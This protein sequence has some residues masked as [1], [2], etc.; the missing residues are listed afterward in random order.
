[1]PAAIK[2]LELIR[3]L[4]GFD[5]TSRE[6]N[7]ALIEFVR[8]YLRQFG[9]AS[10]L[11]WNA[12]GSKANL[13][14]TIGPA[15]RPGVILSG[16][17]DVVPV[18]GQEWSSD[19]FT[20]READGRLYGRGTADMKGFIAIALALVPEMA[21]KHLAHPIHLAFSYDEE[22][23]CSGVQSLIGWLDRQQVK[24]QLCLV[25][26]PTDLRPTI[27]HKGGRAYKVHVHGS[28]AHSSLAPLAV[29]AVEYAA[30]L[31]V[32]LKGV[33]NEMAST[34]PREEGYDIVHSTLQTG[35]VHGGT[36]INIV[37]QT[38]DFVFEFRH[39]PRVDPDAIFA[40]VERFAKEQLEPRMQ[41]VNPQTG[42]RFS[43]VYAYPSLDIAADHPAVR[44]V[45]SLVERN[46]DGKV[47][48]GTEGGLFQDR[49]G[50]P[51]IVCGPGSITQAHKPDEYVSVDQVL[52]C[53]ALIA[54]II[55]R[56]AENR[57]LFAG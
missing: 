46:D 3:T 30:E 48:F 34:G 33:A 27:A 32:F 10:E 35:M 36:A 8:D 56:A 25:G 43:Q 37:P 39:L 5:T 17:T 40:R 45:K 15:E 38:C 57:S 24:P 29:N 13:W 51:T 54:R 52:R 23:G 12:E 42:I 7:R 50:I 53:E 21:K 20:L 4:I 55:D 1:M 22:V 28:E 14:A 26:E 16:H 18:D 49:L 19:P 11:I 9:I 41:A 6:P 31:I 2:S 47:A 44:L